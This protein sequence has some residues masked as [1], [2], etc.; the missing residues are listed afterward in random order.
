MKMN[1]NWQ[2]VAPNLTL[3]GWTYQPSTTGE[4]NWIGLRPQPYITHWIYPPQPIVVRP[5]VIIQ[6]SKTEKPKAKITR[7]GKKGRKSGVKKETF[8]ALVLDKSGSMFNSYQAALDA[9][10]EQIETI[11]KNAKKGGETFVTLILFNHEIEIIYENVPASQVDKL[12]E[13]DYIVGGTTALRDAMS[14]TI[15]TLY[16]YE[17]DDKNQG[18]LTILISDGM[19][20]SSGTTKDELKSK[21]DECDSEKW[22]F[23]YMLGGS[24][25]DQVQ[26]WVW[27][28]GASYGNTVSY[29]SSMAG[30]VTAGQNLA[31]SVGSYFSARSSGQQKTDEFY[32]SDVQG[33]AEVNI[34]EK[35]DE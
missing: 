19:E 20:N 26:D 11:K 30:T 15:D 5:N 35:D 3:S 7:R 18:F 22:T 27:S 34:S 33:S 29:T 23:T 10:N 2:Q 4:N 17:D 9:I 16:E 14:V 1:H 8:V 32:H 28:V 12:T 25:W 31:S 6:P 21:I 24:T 13:E